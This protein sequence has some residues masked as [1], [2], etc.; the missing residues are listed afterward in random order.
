MLGVRDDDADQPPVLVVEDMPGSGSSAAEWLVGPI[1]A[2]HD[3]DHV[4]GNSLCVN[5][6]HLEPVTPHENRRRGPGGAKEE[7]S[8]HRSSS[9]HART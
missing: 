7:I 1:P 5:P 2:D 4:C 8:C 9:S 6:A 3:I